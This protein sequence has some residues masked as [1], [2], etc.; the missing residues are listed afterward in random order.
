MSISDLDA[1]VIL[2]YATDPYSG[3]QTR[4]SQKINSDI[5]KNTITK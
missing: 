4:S 5:I 3:R 2:S 1:S